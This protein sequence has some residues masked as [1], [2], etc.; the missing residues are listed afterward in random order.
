LLAQN[1]LVVE[2]AKGAEDHEQENGGWRT[3]SLSGC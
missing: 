3:L 2:Q 1:L